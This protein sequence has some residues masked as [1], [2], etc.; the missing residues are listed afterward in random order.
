MEI[1]YSFI[2]LKMKWISIFL[3]VILSLDIKNVI[4]Q[5]WQM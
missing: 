2:L 5:L 3:V 1:A 4:A